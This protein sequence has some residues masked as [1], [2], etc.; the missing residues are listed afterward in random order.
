ML[1]AAKYRLRAVLPPALFLA[2]TGYFAW[3][4]VHGSR[5]L[6]AQAAER[7]QLA[8]A[9]ADFAKQDALR[10][11]WEMKISS[12]ADKSVAR[13]MLDDQARAVLN[14]ASPSDIVVPLPLQPNTGAT[15]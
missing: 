11:Q 6:E 5:G 8:S 9:Q 15:K 10:G 4:A 1:K 12:L 2:I 14:L 13:D 3:N 7:V